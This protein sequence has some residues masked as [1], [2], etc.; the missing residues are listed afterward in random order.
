MAKKNKTQ[1][2]NTPETETVE[3]VPEV[4]RWADWCE[5]NWAWWSPGRIILVFAALFV[6][7][8]LIG[9]VMKSGQM[10]RVLANRAYETGQWEKAY[11]KYVNIYG[12]DSKIVGIQ[13]RLGY[14]LA[15]LGR[16]EQAIQ[17][18]NK[19]EA[20]A[21]KNRRQPR[22]QA[23][24][25]ALQ[26]R[27]QAREGKWEQARQDA[28]KAL[29]F[30]EDQP[31]AQATLLEYALEKENWQMA[32]EYARN[33][34]KQKA[35]PELTQSFYEKMASL[36]ASIATEELEDVPKEVPPVS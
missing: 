19:A 7:L 31:R 16:D 24:L 28:E 3:T 22:E 23:L 18:L 8:M 9:I 36:A 35:Y 34:K 17:H 15:E 21:E 30:V 32:G 10:S 26:S 4:S 5:R 27:V 29:Q 1:S 12:E 2:P 6:A 33:L 25:Y 13:L 20:L 14:C 11:K